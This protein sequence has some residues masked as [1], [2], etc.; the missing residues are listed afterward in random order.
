MPLPAPFVTV[1]LAGNPRGKGRPRFGRRGDFVAVWTDKKTKSYEDDLAAVARVAMKGLAVRQGAVSV[2]IET[3]T[4]IPARWSQKKR[5]AAL[6]GD[7]QPIGKP[8]ADNTQKAAFDALNKIVW[9]DDAQIIVCAFRKFYAAEP[10]LTIMA[11][12]W[13]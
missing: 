4:V 8:D 2:R 1:H 13:E 12:D 3:G 6:S 10:G 5:L 7:L 9:H 11:W